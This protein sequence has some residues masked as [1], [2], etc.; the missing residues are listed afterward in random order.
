MKD[1]LSTNEIHKL[2][3]DKVWLLLEKLGFKVI[4]E[5]N[6]HRQLESPSIRIGLTGK[7]ESLVAS[8][9]AKTKSV[10]PNNQ[11]IADNEKTKLKIMVDFQTAITQEEKTR[12]SNRG[13][14]S[15]DDL[16]D[17]PEI[18]V[19]PYY[20][21]K[22]VLLEELRFSYPYCNLNRPEDLDKKYNSHGI[23]RYL[24]LDERNTPIWESN[25]GK[26]NYVGCEL[27]PEVL[28]LFPET[29]NI[30]EVL[31]KLFSGLV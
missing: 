31:Q 7:K 10:W 16:R 4:A 17:P 5:N 12:G 15:Q 8:I 9:K 3:Q 23:P 11:G 18:Y 2:A 24:G 13:C 28:K 22:P 20:L 30:S 19:I 21:W 6:S 1:C 29:S 25:S 14:I 27:R 26:P